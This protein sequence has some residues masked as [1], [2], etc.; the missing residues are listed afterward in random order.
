MCDGVEDC[1]SGFDELKCR[2]LTKLFT[3]SLI[4]YSDIYATIHV[5]FVATFAHQ[6]DYAN[7]VYVGTTGGDNVPTFNEEK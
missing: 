3:I 7:S 2:K 1:S 6:M 4:V 5:Y